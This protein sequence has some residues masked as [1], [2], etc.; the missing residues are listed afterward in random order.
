M[1]VREDMQ[2][3]YTQVYYLRWV[4]EYCPPQKC[5][6]YKIQET[7]N[8]FFRNTWSL[9]SIIHRVIGILWRG[10]TKRHLIVG[11]EATGL[12]GMQDT[13]K[14]AVKILKSCDSPLENL[15]VISL[16]VSYTPSNFKSHHL[17]LFQGQNLWYKLY[18]LT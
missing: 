3:H 16:V 9:I 10:Y 7:L 14:M 4:S 12:K 2:S 13:A 6:L 8:V 15:G 1:I 17:L 18:N 11:A 5:K